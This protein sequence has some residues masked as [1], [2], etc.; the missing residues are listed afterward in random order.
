MGLI[1]ILRA[2]WTG[3]VGK[4]VGAKWKN[5][6]TIRTYSI[7]SD[8][9]T[10]AQ[11][12]VRLGFGD[13][14][15][16]LALFTD[17]LKYINGLNTKGMSV[18]NAIVKLNRDMVVSGE[19]TPENVLLSKGGLQAPQGASITQA[20]SG[21]TITA[22]WTDPTATNFTDKATAVLVVVQP[23]DNI[24]DVVTAK[25]SEKT[26][27]TG[28]SFAGEGEI[29]AYLYFFDYRGTA[30]IGSPS[31]GQKVTKGE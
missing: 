17:N 3:K 30:K 31:I 22:T 28:V 14:N 16:L 24:A 19:L 23:D 5:K 11:E 13:L 12:T 8:P 21:G 20:S 7:P 9:K 26:L 18:R 2:D 6:S 27:E 25:V 1:N 15:K 29:Y 4:T 10:Q